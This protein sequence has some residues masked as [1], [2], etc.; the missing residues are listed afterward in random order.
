M[1]EI[2]LFAGERQMSLTQVLQ[3]PKLLAFVSDR[4]VVANEDD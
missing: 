2:I 4:E 1:G 3:A